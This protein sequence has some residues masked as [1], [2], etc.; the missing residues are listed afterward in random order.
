[1]LDE[2]SIAAM[3]AKIVCG[4][5]NNQLAGDTDADLMQQRDILYA[6]DYLANAGGIISASAEFLGEDVGK[7]EQRVARIPLRLSCVFDR[8]EN[9]R[10]SPAV[11]AD[12]M[13]RE[14]IVGTKRVPHDTR[15]AS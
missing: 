5:A 14:I 12:E 10:V 8:A 11:V 7:V 4:A 3:R 6:P 2:R 13:A 1:V 15:V 9:K